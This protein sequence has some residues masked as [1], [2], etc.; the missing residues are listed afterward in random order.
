M[1]RFRR[2]G[3]RT[4]PMTGDNPVDLTIVEV[5]HVQQTSTTEILTG[6]RPLMQVIYQTWWQTR[7]F[8][9]SLGGGLRRAPHKLKHSI[10]YSRG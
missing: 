10:F 7:R 2:T 5:T 9:I 3:L 8:E 6:C 1:L 4:E